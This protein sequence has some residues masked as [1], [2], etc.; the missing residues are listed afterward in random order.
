[1]ISNRRLA[2]LLSSEGDDFERT[3]TITLKRRNWELPLLEL[4]N[5]SSRTSS[6][7]NLNGIRSGKV[8]DGDDYSE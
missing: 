1:M 8:A 6:Q 2:R 5:I 3:A 7:A 4:R